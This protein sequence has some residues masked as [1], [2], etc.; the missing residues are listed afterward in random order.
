MENGELRVWKKEIEVG[1]ML[2]DVIEK[3]S[4]KGDKGV[5]LCVDLEWEWVYGDEELLK[6]GMGNLVENCIKY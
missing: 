1:G 5:D 3:Y 6:E 4:G 2:E